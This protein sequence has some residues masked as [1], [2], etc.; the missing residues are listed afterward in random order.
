MFKT[1][2][3]TVVL[4]ISKVIYNEEFC[5]Y[6]RG[7]LVDRYVSILNDEFEEQLLNE[8]KLLIEIEKAKHEIVSYMKIKDLD[9][10]GYKNQVYFVGMFHTF[11][12]SINSFKQIES[13][14]NNSFHYVNLTC[15]FHEKGAIDKTFEGNLFEIVLKMKEI[16]NEISAKNRLEQ[17]F[18]QKNDHREIKLRKFFS[19]GANISKIVSSIEKSELNS[20]VDRFFKE[21]Y[22]K[23]VD[24]SDKD[25]DGI[26]D[27]NGAFAQYSFPSNMIFVEKSKDDIK[28]QYF[29]KN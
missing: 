5:Y 10:F 22:I 12:I 21:P 25:K 6:V 28:S 29:Y 17:V 4:D 7:P 18:E 8:I 23:E 3:S 13:L 1:D 27:L 11:D 20:I 15:T 9:S 26:V 16:I 24:Y 2:S 14:L 19:T